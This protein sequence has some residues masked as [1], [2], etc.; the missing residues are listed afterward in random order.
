MQKR[1]FLRTMLERFFGSAVIK[2]AVSFVKFCKEQGYFKQKELKFYRN[3]PIN[4]I[5]VEQKL[6]NRYLFNGKLKFENGK[7]L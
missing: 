3:L 2:T 7:L 5:D 4:N 1:I 6:D